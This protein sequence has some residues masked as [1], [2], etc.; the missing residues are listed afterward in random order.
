MPL[1]KYHNAHE[2]LHLSADHSLRTAGN[3]LHLNKCYSL[4]FT[5]DHPLNENLCSTELPTAKPPNY[6]SFSTLHLVLHREMLYL[7]SLKG[8]IFNLHKIPIT[9]AQRIIYH[10]SK[11]LPQYFGIRPSTLKRTWESIS[12]VNTSTCILTMRNLFI[13]QPEY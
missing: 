1:L 13:R 5:S 10:T 8:S 7:D 11:Y 9:K 4:P 3:L 2:V 12:S 6:F